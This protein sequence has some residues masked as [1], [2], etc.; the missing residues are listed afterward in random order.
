[1]GPQIPF[2][3]SV[4][5][6]CVVLK[7]LNCYGYVC[8]LVSL[9]R[10]GCGP[11]SICHA[12]GHPAQS[13][14]MRKG[15]AGSQLSALLHGI[16]FLSCSFGLR[17]P[18]LH[19]RNEPVMGKQQPSLPYA[20]GTYWLPHRVCSSQRPAFENQLRLLARDKTYMSLRGRV[21]MN[22]SPNLLLRLWAGHMTPLSLYFLKQ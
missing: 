21:S 12:P 19:P 3:L 5:L 7:S 4:C 18:R 15:M 6:S 10:W 22:L 11:D 9:V 13:E 17:Q 1:M 16:L 8:S 20:C 2:F 14:K